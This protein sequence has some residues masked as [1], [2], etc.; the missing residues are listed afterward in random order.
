MQGVLLCS[1][2]YL[3]K[4]TRFYLTLAI[5]DNVR[6]STEEEYQEGNVFSIDED[7]APAWINN[8]VEQVVLFLYYRDMDCGSGFLMTLC[9]KSTE[10]FFCCY[11]T[12]F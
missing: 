8:S 10:G 9:F 2:A 7:S 1:P 11:F 5:I 4:T 3:V 12:N 6:E